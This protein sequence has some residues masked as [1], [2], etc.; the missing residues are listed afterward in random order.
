M[1]SLPTDVRATMLLADH[2]VVAEGKL[3]IAGAGW[4]TISSAPAPFA[5]ALLV[6]VPWTMTDQ[7]LSFQLRLV[8]ADGQPVLVGDGAVQVDGTFQCA[9]PPGAPPGSR[10]PVPLA[11]TFAGLPLPPGQRFIWELAIDDQTNEEWRLAFDVRPA[12]VT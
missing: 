4:T 7:P 1:T 12:P 3:Y 6:D 5:I 9:R 11:F 2:A 10:I 8:T